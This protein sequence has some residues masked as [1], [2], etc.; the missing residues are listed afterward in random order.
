MISCASV[1]ENSNEDKEPQLIGLWQEVK[2][3]SAI[4]HFQKDGT[5]KIYLRKGELAGRRTIDGHW[6]IKNNKMKVIIDPD[7]IN[8]IDELSISFENDELYITDT[9]G[10][11]IKHR[12][13]NGE[14]PEEYNW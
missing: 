10:D 4:I 1:V 5:F 12:R 2:E 9:Y 11:V 8:A 13:L 7:G 3:S 6:K 14:I